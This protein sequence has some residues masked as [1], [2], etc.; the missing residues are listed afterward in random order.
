MIRKM[1]H[2]ALFYLPLPTQMH[3]FLLSSNLLKQNETPILIN[4]AGGPFTWAL[5]RAWHAL[6][7]AFCV[8]ELPA[9]LIL[10]FPGDQRLTVG[11]A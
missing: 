5:D 4:D 7:P 11:G 1:R 10:M 3:D 9:K 6:R 8:I 2:W